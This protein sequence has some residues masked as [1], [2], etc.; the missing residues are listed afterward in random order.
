MSNGY[1]WVA[2]S[3]RLGD[4]D[5]LRALRARFK[6]IGEIYAVRVI[7]SASRAD[8]DGFLMITDSR[9]HTPQTFAEFENLPSEDA[10]NIFNEMVALKFLQQDEEGRYYLPNWHELNKPRKKAFDNAEYQR[11]FRAKPQPDGVEQ[12]PKEPDGVERQ[13]S[14]ELEQEVSKTRKRRSKVSA[15]DSATGDFQE[16]YSAYPLHVARKKA[17]TAYRNALQTVTHE[18]IMIGLNRQLAAK[19]FN[20]DAQF[21]KHPATWLNQGCWADE[22]AI[23]GKAS[24]AN[25]SNVAISA[26]Y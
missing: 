4:S 5:A 6:W 7:C 9:P 13:Q 23:S 18:E 22:V 8:K 10:Q 3:N 2:I 20:K 17:A 14:N 25:D 19:A 24:N 1:Y 26:Y 16:F 11:K 15:D 21:I 12:L